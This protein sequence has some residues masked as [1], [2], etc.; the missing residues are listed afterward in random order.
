[1][2]A[3]QYKHGDKPLEGFTIQRAAGR[4]GFGEV[5]YAIS[6]SGREV[7][8]KVIQGYEQIELRGVSQCMN[9]KS[10]HLVA[11]FDVKHNAEGTPFVIMEYVSGPSL[12]ELCDQQPAG[13]GIQKAAF[14]LREIGKGLTYRHDCGIVHRY[15]KA[16]N[17]FY[18]NGYVNIGKCALSKA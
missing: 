6:D 16:G 7:A 8:L 10:P 15:L 1:M 3:F 18:A 11:I 2:W 5:Y 17:I 9:L 13:L 12:R 14:F 4:G